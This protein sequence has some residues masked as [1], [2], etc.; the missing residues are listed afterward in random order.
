MASLTGASIA[1]S[2]TSLLKL[3]GNTDTLVAGA[4]GNA[5]QVVDGD[6]TASP[7]YLN[8]DRLGIGTSSPN[9]SLT[10]AGT[11][12]NTI[13]N[14]SISSSNSTSSGITLF[15]TSSGSPSSSSRKW[16]IMTNYAAEGDF[17]IRRSSS[18]TG[19]L[20]TYVLKLDSDSRISISNNDSNTGN[21]VFGYSA[22]NTSS[23]NASDNNAVFGHNAMGTGAVAGASNNVAVGQSSL[24]AITTGNQNVSIGSAAM[25]TCTTSSNN[26]GIGFLALDAITTQAGGVVAVGSQ[27]LTEL[28]SGLYNTA[29]GTQSSG[30]QQTGNNNTTIG[31]KS[32]FNNTDGGSTTAVGYQSGFDY[33]SGNVTTAEKCTFI[34]KSTRASSATPTNQI[35]IGYEADG[36]ADNSVTLGNENVTAVYMSHDS[37]ATVH[38]GNVISNSNH[39]VEGYA[40]GRNVIRSI[41][42]DISPG[43]TPNTNINVDH[44]ATAGRSF[45]TPSLTD[46]TNIANNASSGSFALNDGSTRIN[47][48]VNNAIGILS[49]SVVVHDLNSSGTGGGGSYV[50]GEIYFSNTVISSNDLSIALM[51]AG[52]Q[53]LVD[54]RTVLDAGD[55]MTILI[56][57]MASS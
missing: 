17:V 25:Q 8:T 55:S 24:L 52:S 4:S 39:A 22:F 37:G 36:V 6:G 7:L 49:D 29:V 35:V 26:V 50:A 53:S 46:G 21:T 14:L 9:T 20:D 57:Y 41:R 43:D 15:N 16:G 51:K 54:W 48:D 38:A 12:S 5:I 45:N 31:Y 13:G 40:T 32:L 47:I 2:Y 11:Q 28:T 19:N 18:H 33:T 44:D 23:D 34:G 27:C 56:T 42:L 10:I 1:S 30:S 3:S